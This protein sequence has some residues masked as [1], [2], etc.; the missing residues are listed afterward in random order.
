[1]LLGGSA[2]R[3]HAD[4]FSDIEMAVV[5]TEAPSEADRVAAIAAAGGDVVSLYPPDAGVWAVAWKIGRRD[6]IA[7]TGI[8][9]DMSHC[10]VETIEQILRDVIDACDPDPD[11]QLVVGGILHATPL[12]GRALAEQ[13]QKRAAGYPDGLRLAVV[14]AHA[15]IEGLWRLDAFAARDNPVP[16]TRCS[17][18]PTRNCSTCCSG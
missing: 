6:G 10:L 13:W 5:W 14:R 9:M 11:K 15:Q 7:F 4:R 16:A 3:G 2:A 17:R 18:R 8:E 1:V 12:H